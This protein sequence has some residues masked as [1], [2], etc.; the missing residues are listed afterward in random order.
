MLTAGGFIFGFWPCEVLGVLVAVFAGSGV[1]AVALGLLVDLA[2][3]T[4]TGLL[5]YLYFPFS[6]LAILAI[7]ARYIGTR[8]FFE[9]LP[10][11]TL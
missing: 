2:H 10:H 7:A 4:P 1:A 3:G 6:L 9:R 8:F 11:D 5:H